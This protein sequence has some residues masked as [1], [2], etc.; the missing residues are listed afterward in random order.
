MAKRSVI[1]ALS[2]LQALV[3]LVVWYSNRI[4]H[5]KKRAEFDAGK[6]GCCISFNKTCTYPFVAKSWNRSMVTRYRPYLSARCDSL[7]A[8]EALEVERVKSVLETWR[9]FRSDELF[10][11][12]LHNCTYVQEMFSDN[13][14]TSPVETEFPLAF[15]MTIHDYP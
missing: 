8:G 13:F 10:L 9:N 4:F 14:Y 6:D 5:T 1:A 7:W 11:T 2:C 3:I 15:L 12:Q